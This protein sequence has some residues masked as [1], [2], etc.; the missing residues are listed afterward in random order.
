M[1]PML[2]ARTRF[3]AGCI[4][5]NTIVV[6]GGYS[7]PTDADNGAPLSSVHLFNI[8]SNSWTVAAPLA[9]PRSDS[10]GAVLNNI[11]YLIGGYEANYVTSSAFS[12]FDGKIWTALPSMITGRG[13]VGAAT[14]NG[15]VVAVGGWNNGMFKLNY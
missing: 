15:M 8:A 7:N 13:D 9:V 10:G 2:I 3:A 12:S 6:A 5:N 14:L 11:F 4:N 1:S